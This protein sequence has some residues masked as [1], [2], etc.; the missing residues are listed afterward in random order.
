MI[1]KEEG[2]RKKGGSAAVLVVC[3]RC[4]HILIASYILLNRH[5]EK[6]LLSGA[7]NCLQTRHGF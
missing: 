5:I 6:A 3:F 7:G 1:G 4:L 2:K